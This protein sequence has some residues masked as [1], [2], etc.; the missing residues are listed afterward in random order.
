MVVGFVNV[1]LMNLTRAIG[2][3]MGANMPTR[4]FSSSHLSA[5]TRF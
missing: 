4:K 2:V 1:A 5:T 3:I